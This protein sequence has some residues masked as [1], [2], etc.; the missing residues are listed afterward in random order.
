MTISL[1]MG[2]MRFL[3]RTNLKIFLVLKDR[4]LLTQLS[5]KNHSIIPL[6]VPYSHLGNEVITNISSDVLIK[7]QGQE[8]IIE[9]T[10]YNELTLLIFV[11]LI[12][13]QRS[14]YLTTIPVASSDSI[15]TFDVELII[16]N[17]QR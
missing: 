6:S 9:N 1:S 11:S 3:L 12:A 7:S 4:R 14:L 15:D 8:T 10:T 16:L 2:V 13:R 5:K 17:V